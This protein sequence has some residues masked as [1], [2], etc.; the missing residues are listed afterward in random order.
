VDPAAYVKASF[1]VTIV[2]GDVYS[3]LI[4]PLAPESTATDQS[5]PER[6]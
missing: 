2:K 6:S 1:L 3:E 5:L 4:N